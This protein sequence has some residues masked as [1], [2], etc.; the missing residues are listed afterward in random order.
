MAELSLEAFSLLFQALTCLYTETYRTCPHFAFIV[1]L[2]LSGCSH[3][4]IPPTVT[5]SL[6][7]ATSPMSPAMLTSCSPGTHAHVDMRVQRSIQP[8]SLRAGWVKPVLFLWLPPTVAS[9]PRPLCLGLFSFACQIRFFLAPLSFLQ[10]LPAFSSPCLPYKHPV[11]SLS[12]LLSP[13]PASLLMD[14]PT[15]SHAWSCSI[16]FYPVSS[17]CLCFVWRF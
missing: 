10:S 5:T 4:Q 3:F 15:W 7:T 9:L 1:L 8:C 12:S 14:E 2:L 17:R 16:Q 11:S 13:T 6:D